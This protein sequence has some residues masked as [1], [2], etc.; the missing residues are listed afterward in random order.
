VVAV[1]K[2]GGLTSH[3]VVA[4][5]RRILGGVKV[6]HAG[7]LDPD[8]TG[9]LVLCIGKATKISSF[10]M[11]AEKTYEGEGRLGA[12]TDTQDAS[13]HVL[14]ERPVETSGD[15]IREAARRFVGRI[16]QTPPMFS[17]VKIEGRKLY[18]LARRG[19][20]VER[21]ARPVTVHAFEIRSVDLPD[22]RFTIRCSKGTYVR[23]LVNDLGET[24]GCGAHLTRLRRSR[25]GIFA[26]ERAVPWADLKSSRAAHTIHEESVGPERALEFL[27][28]VTLSPAGPLPRVG[29]RVPVAESP[30]EIG[31]S[32]V[33]LPSGEFLGIARADRECL[34][35]MYLAPTRT[36]FGRRKRSE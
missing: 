21:P 13:G 4:T 5:V 26:V 33:V 16:E 18:R 35:I 14:R 17:A 30:A 2:P 12:T 19:V 24:V 27:P 36:G 22:F 11:E 15:A 34:R 3:D 6:G 20:E 32:R 23:T 7:T 31:L 10:L 28:A 1:D 25:Q 8:A 29:G 9:V